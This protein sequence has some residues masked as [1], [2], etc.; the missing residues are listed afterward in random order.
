MNQWLSLLFILIFAPAI[1]AAEPNALQHFTP[2][3]GKLTFTQTKHIQG[4]PVPLQSSG[5]IELEGEDLLWHTTKPL[6]SKLLINPAGVSQ[7]QEQQ[8]VAVGGSEFVGQLMLAVLK[9]QDQ[10]IAEH[11]AISA[12][13]KEQCITL[14][15]TQA[16]LN[17]LFLHITLCGEHALQK[18]ELQE[19]NENH[20]VIH[21]AKDTPLE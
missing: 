18:I 4:L 19:V 16:P 11:F 7:W 6:D 1:L 14:T 10:F 17:T 15:P 3:Q 21:L 12:L 9:Q 13:S 8:F 20:T 5:Y 2:M